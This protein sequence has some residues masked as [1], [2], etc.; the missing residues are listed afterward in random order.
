M[1]DEELEL[2]DLRD[3][4]KELHNGLMAYMQH[5]LADLGMDGMTVTTEC[6]VFGKTETKELKPGGAS[7]V[8]SSACL[9]ACFHSW[10]VAWTCFAAIVKHTM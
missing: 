9:L 3:V 4:D 8:V 7:I 6:H 1:L 10:L 2:A 5:P